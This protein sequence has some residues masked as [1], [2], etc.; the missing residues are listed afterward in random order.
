MKM[1][2]H[3][4]KSLL[5]KSLERRK[6]LRPPWSLRSRGSASP[7]RPHPL[8]RVC[9]GPTSTVRATLPSPDS[10]VHH[11]SRRRCDRLIRSGGRATIVRGGHDSTP[12]PDHPRPPPDPSP[13]RPLPLRRRPLLHL[14]FFPDHPHRLSPQ[15]FLLSPPLAAV[16]RVRAGYMRRGGASGFDVGGPLPLWR[17]P[18]ASPPALSSLASA[19]RRLPGF[20]ISA[21]R[22]HSSLLPLGASSWSQ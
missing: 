8:A 9:Q 21:G 13:H 18:S 3:F 11:S 14:P 1:L 5:L 15:F 16:L 2:Q 12:P 7:R 10:H 17:R 4:A 22:P 20:V 6:K 19:S